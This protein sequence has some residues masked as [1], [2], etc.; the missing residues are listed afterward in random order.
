M[1]NKRKD[2]IDILKEKS[3]L[4]GQFT[5]YEILQLIEI[6]PLCEYDE[7]ATIYKEGEPAT[8]LKF[9]ING[10]VNIHLNNHLVAQLTP[11]DVFG[12]AMFSDQGKRIADAVAVEPAEVLQFDLAAYEEMLRQDTKV[13]LKCKH[14]FEELY[15]NNVIANEHFFTKDTTK[16]LAL[17]A[18]NEMKVPLVQFVQSN[19]KKINKFPLVAT[20]TTGELLYKEAKILLSKK[21]KSG[22]L[23][24]D[25]AIGQMISTDN[26]KGI[27]FF[28]DPLSP[29]PHH[30]DIEALG[31]LCDVYQVPLATNPATATAVLDYLVT[32]PD[33]EPAQVNSLL[34]DYGREQA[35]VVQDKSK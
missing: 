26:I 24:G 31:R 7:N 25:Q 34:S 17:V 22:P 16:Y 6:M 1:D 30:A 3:P 13:A 20:G 27:I 11:G 18:H 21:V 23:G 35:K 10:A 8:S 28:R 33:K 4:S 5:D 19:L 32:N 9:L 15:K 14:I 29:H 12:E 2:L